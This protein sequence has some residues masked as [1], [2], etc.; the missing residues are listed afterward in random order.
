MSNWFK[1]SETKGTH[2]LAP[3]TA[4]EAED[5]AIGI[6]AVISHCGSVAE[7]VII[8]TRFVTVPSPVV[9]PATNTLPPTF[10]AT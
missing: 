6:A 1:D 10:A 2:Q 8:S 3:S 7:G 9:P 4:L 5:K